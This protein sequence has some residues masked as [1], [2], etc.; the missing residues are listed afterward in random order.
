M[1]AFTPATINYVGDCTLNRC[2]M[3]G[4]SAT[5]TIIPCCNCGYSVRNFRRFQMNM[6]DAMRS[7]EAVIRKQEKPKA[8]KS[9]QIRDGLKNLPHNRKKMRF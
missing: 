2:I 6:Q 8:A 1:I 9:K 3:N 4:N 7:A 5:A